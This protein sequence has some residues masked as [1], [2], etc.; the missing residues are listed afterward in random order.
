M[1][2]NQTFDP[3]T[4]YERVNLFSTRLFSDAG[5]QADADGQ[6]E[7]QAILSADFQVAPAVAHGSAPGG[8]REDGRE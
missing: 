7:T 6:E 5:P 1:R 2:W 3:D 8:G 4:S